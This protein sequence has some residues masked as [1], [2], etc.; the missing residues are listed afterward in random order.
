MV[1]SSGAW[2][3][4]E[5]LVARK[6]GDWWCGNEDAFKRAPVSGGWPK[7]RSHG[8]ILTN[9]DIDQPRDVITS[10]RKFM[11]L[12]AID[13]KRRIKGSAGTEWHLEQLL[14]APKHPVFDWWED[15]T[16]LANRLHRMRMLIFTKAKRQ[17]VLMF[18][19]EGIAW[20]R[21]RL[22]SEF[23]SLS[24][25]RATFYVEGMTEELTVFDLGKFLKKI[26]ARLL[27]GG[28]VCE[29]ESKEES[30]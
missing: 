2:K 30:S 8:D 16:Q 7:K 19:P 29:E 28:C 13:V 1:S 9:D 24:R 21:D 12:F 17:Y 3:S 15:V 6:L 22:G 11:S 18:G 5:R 4:A 23:D 20:L 26:D 27:G 10:A 25:T 14:S